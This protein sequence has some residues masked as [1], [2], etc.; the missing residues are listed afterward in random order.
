MYPLDFLALP[1]GALSC[2]LSI[3]PISLC[4]PLSIFRDSRE[5]GEGVTALYGIL[6]YEIDHIYIYIYIYIYRERERERERERLD[7]SL[8]K[9]KAQSLN[10]PRVSFIKLNFRYCGLFS[11]YLALLHKFQIKFEYLRTVVVK[12][13]LS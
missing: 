13:I 6:R 12:H 2:P 10:E 11:N 1:L 9:L 3:H 5:N 7:G 8:L 4:H